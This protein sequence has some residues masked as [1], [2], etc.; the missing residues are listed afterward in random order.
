[1]CW[2]GICKGDGKCCRCWWHCKDRQCLE[3][4]DEYCI[5]GAKRE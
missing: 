2:E 4:A 1:M 5:G 3:G